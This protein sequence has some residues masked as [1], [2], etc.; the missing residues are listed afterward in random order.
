MLL[1]RWF[2]FMAAFQAAIV[3]VAA[4]A[5]SA[6]AIG[7][8]NLPGSFCQCFGYGNGAG[9]HSCLVLGPSS[10]HGFCATNEVRLECPPQPP[11]G[12][13]AGGPCNSMT[14]GTWMEVPEQIQRPCPNR[15]PS[16][17]LLRARCGRKFN[18]GRKSGRFARFGRNMRQQIA[19]QT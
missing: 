6:W 17:R 2:Q 4:S 13:Y 11:Y 9:H 3:C 14:H 18:I 10:C 8:Y 19:V 12:Y 7:Y 5:G 16:R 15:C 1:R